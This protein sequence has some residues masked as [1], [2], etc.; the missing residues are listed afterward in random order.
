V[1]RFAPL[2]P[3]GERVLD[4]ACGSGRHTRLFLDR[5]HPV[6]AVDRDLSGLDDLHSHPALETLGVDLEDG[7]AFPLAGQSFAGVVVTNY[8]WRPI[9]ADL[10]AAVAKGGVLLYET[11]ASGHE[12]F[13]PPRNRDFLLRP[14]E[15]LEAV[16]GRLRVLAYEDLVVEEPRLAAVQ[17][18]CAQ[19]V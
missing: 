17:R 1:V 13:G 4:V 12:R 11:F 15:L 10:V 8:L 3:P 14:G 2:V 6:L 19:R 18:I 9:L 5:G 7:S 16:R